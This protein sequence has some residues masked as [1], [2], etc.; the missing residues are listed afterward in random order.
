MHTKKW[1]YSLLIT[2]L[3]LAAYN[4]LLVTGL[5]LGSKSAQH[6]DRAYLYDLRLADQ[7]RWHVDNLVAIPDSFVT[8]VNV[9]AQRGKPTQY[10]W[11]SYGKERFGQL[12]QKPTDTLSAQLSDSLF[13]LTQRVF[14]DIPALSEQ[15]HFIEITD[16]ASSKIE[17]NTF[18][19]TINASIITDSYSHIGPLLFLLRHSRR[20]KN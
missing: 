18:D 11:S 1:L 8:V 5:L 10:A 20:H 7:V 16:G 17:L 2:G 14:A 12:I 13:Y 3:L 4:T 9:Y 6:Q 15:D 19:N